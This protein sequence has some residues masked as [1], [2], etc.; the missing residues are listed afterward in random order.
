MTRAALLVTAATLLAACSAAQSD[1]AQYGPNPD[2]PA[3]WRTGAELNQPDPDTFYGG[4]AE[5]YT[6]YPFLDD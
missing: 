1:P 3:R 6:D 2:L 4:G 5:G